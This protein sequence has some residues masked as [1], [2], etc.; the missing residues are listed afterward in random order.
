MKRCDMII[1]SSLKAAGVFQ[2]FPLTVLF[3]WWSVVR[4]L[5]TWRWQTNVSVFNNWLN[6]ENYHIYLHTHSSSTLP[7]EPQRS[8]LA[9]RHDSKE[10]FH[11]HDCANFIF[12]WFTGQV[13]L[14]VCSRTNRLRV[15]DQR[16]QTEQVNEPLRSAHVCSVGM[17]VFGWSWRTD[18]VCKCLHQWCLRLIPDSMKMKSVVQ[19]CCWCVPC[20]GG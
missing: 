1:Y 19:Q 14:R 15:E 3:W 7:S 12:R 11:H 13:Y 17:K 2:S 18:G 9:D 20:T 10:R 6:N 8:Y 5:C 4:L 16:M